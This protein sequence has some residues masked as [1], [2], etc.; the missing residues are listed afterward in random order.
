[1]ERPKGGFG[2]G[3]NEDRRIVVPYWSF[4]KAYPQLE[5][6]GIRIEA[7]PGKLPLAIDESRV[8]LR[9]NRKVAYD[10]PDDFEYNTAESL[11]RD[12]H[13]IVGMIG[14][15]ISVIASVGLM[16][17]GVGVMNIMLVSVTERTRE[18]GVRKAI[19]ARRR[20]IIGQFL[21]EAVTLTAT[22]G[23]L[24]VIFGYLTTAGIRA[25]GLSATIPLW[26]VGLGV[27]VAASVGLFFGCT[28]R[29]R[30]RGWTP[31]WRCGTSNI[32]PSGNV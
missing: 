29:S 31:W 3:G 1:M 2:P 17:G 25:L 27:V 23:V 12:F 20:D 10:K 18:I 8:A 24:G 14:L 11:I 6:H 9:R 30:R 22:G 21:V 26:S 16:I 4:R 15:V 7:Y 32:R 5:E 28:R 13:S 19:G